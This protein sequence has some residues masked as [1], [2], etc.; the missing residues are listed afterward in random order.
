MWRTSSEASLVASRADEALCAASAVLCVDASG[1]V[2]STPL[3]GETEAEGEEEGEEEGAGA[4]AGPSAA[5][6]RRATHRLT[7]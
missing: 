3:V 2:P 4:G 5:S 6:Q 7:R 1:D